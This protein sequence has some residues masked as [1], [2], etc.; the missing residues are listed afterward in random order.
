VDGVALGL[1]LASILAFLIGVTMA[2]K[3]LRAGR[4]R[5][6][7]MLTILLTDPCSSSSMWLRCPANSALTCSREAPN[8]ALQATC[9]THAAARRR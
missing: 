9:E 5:V 7:S 2:I 1:T 3:G 6:E 8:K 4:R